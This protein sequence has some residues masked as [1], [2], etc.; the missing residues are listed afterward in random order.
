MVTDFSRKRTLHLYTADFPYGQKE[1]FLESEINHLASTFDQIVI[2]PLNKPEGQRTM[3]PNVKVVWLFENYSYA[4]A[5]NVL[6]WLSVIV[7]A[8]Y[9]ELAAGKLFKPELKKRF[10]YFLRT[11]SKAKHVEKEFENVVNVL[12]Y[13]YWMDEWATI[14][15]ILKHRG[16]VN[17]FFSR[18]HRFDLYEEEN[19]FGFIPFRRY[20]L[21]KVNLIYS[22]SEEGQGYLCDRHPKFKHLF[23]VSKLGTLK[24]GKNPEPPAEPP[25]VILSCSYV[26]AVKRLELLLNGLSKVSNKVHWIHCGDGPLRE[27][28]MEKCKALPSNIAVTWK[29]AMANQDVL[30]FYA[31]QPAHL[32]V[33]VSSSEGIPVSIMEALSFGIPV[34]ATDVGGTSELVD[35]QVGSLLPKDLSAGF[36]ADKIQNFIDNYDAHSKFRENARQRWED[37]A[38][39]V[40]NYKQFMK[41]LIELHDSLAQG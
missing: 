3:P 32:F 35:E 23:Q 13:S 37:S 9:H 27:S 16:K 33:N 38:N 17:H 24:Y 12:H 26:K 29:G 1:A 4:G 8:L 5:K 7:S 14:L 2:F 31:E 28:L 10:S 34:L 21:S 6:K 40:V 41:Q 25:F 18:A 30:R 39:A 20:Q 36:L 22:I 15:G 11:V 19:E